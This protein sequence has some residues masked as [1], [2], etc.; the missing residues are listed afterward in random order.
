[1]SI[2]KRVWI[3]MD[4]AYAAEREAYVKEVLKY[5]DQFK[6]R[7]PTRRRTLAGNWDIFWPSSLT[8]AAKELEIEYV[9]INSGLFFRIAE[10]RDAV[11]TRADTIHPE[12]MAALTRKR[13]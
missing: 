8:A 3:E 11:R 9:Q 10:E 2:T 13:R 4:P 5:Q 12:R 7:L 6:F 1:M